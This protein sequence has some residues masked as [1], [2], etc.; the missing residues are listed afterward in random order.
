MVADNP[1]IQIPA[2]L[3]QAKATQ[4]ITKYKKGHLTAVKN[5]SV[6][7]TISNVVVAAREVTAQWFVGAKLH[8]ET[9]H[10]DVLIGSGTELVFKDG[11]F[12]RAQ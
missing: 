5:T 12:I 4:D 11:A 6:P 1:N 9:F 2:P 8:T 3:D 7:M 10:A